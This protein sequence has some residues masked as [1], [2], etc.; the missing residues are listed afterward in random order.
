MSV[1]VLLL[2]FLFGS[3]ALQALGYS[4]QG[5]IMTLQPEQHTVVTGK[6]VAFLE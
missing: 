6:T 4:R 5:S 1:C 2:S 3:L